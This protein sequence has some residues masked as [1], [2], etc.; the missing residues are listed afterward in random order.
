MMCLTARGSRPTSMPATL[1]F[2]LSAVRI[3][4]MISTVVVFARSIWAQQ[5][6]NLT[7]L[8]LERNAVDGLNVAVTL[9]QLLHHDDG[10]I[11]VHRPVIVRRHHLIQTSRNYNTGESTKP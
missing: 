4:S 7:L 3:P 11:P 1:A 9:P 8:H 5:G 10:A 2:P 6:K